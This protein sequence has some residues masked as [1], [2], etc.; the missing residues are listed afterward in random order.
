MFTAD[1]DTVQGG[2]LNSLY[3]PTGFILLSQPLEMM[4][5]PLTDSDK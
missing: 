1:L 5:F 2:F 3:R 4:T